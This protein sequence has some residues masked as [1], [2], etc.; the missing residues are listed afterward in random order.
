MITVEIGT[1]NE[2]AASTAARNS[3]PTISAVA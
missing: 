2:K 1:L 3:T